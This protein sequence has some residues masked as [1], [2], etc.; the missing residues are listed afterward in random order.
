MEW[1]KTSAIIL[2]LEITHS[3]V[4]IQPYHKRATRTQM[5]SWMHILD[6]KK[7]TG[8]INW[9]HHPFCGFILYTNRSDFI[10]ARRSGFESVSFTSS[11]YALVVT[12]LISLA[13]LQVLHNHDDV[14][15]WK[16]FPRYWPF[17]RGIQRSPVNS[18]HKSQWRGAL[19]FS[20]ISA[21]RNG[22][23]NNDEGGDF[24]SHRAHYDVIV[25]NGSTK[26]LS[27]MP[28]DLCDKSA[29]DLPEEGAVKR[30]WCDFIVMYL[31]CEH[32]W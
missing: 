24:R 6:Y 5:Q 18:P 2:F 20:L 16:H 26:D 9:S 10:A 19:I 17:V 13:D 30:I 25:M 22:W 28:L 1:Y 23:V 21:W 3:Y 14:I 27:Y 8:N 7:T 15:K 32:V 31:G 12:H 29:L 4:E 11:P